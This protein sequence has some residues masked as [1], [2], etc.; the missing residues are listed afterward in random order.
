MAL[1]SSRTPSIDH[2]CPTCQVPDQRVTACGHCRS[3]FYCSRKCQSLDWNT[4]KTFCMKE[5]KELAVARRTKCLELLEWHSSGIFRY[6][7]NHDYV[8]RSSFLTVYD[9]ETAPRYIPFN[10]LEVL[11]KLD[12][13]LSERQYQALSHAIERTRRVGSDEAHCTGVPVLFMN[14][15]S[16]SVYVLGSQETTKLIEA[17]KTMPRALKSVIMTDVV[18][19]AMATWKP[20]QYVQLASMM[21]SGEADPI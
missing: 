14:G 21:A 9:E 6:I 17:V 11:N 16:R 10:K 15:E 20:S 18:K 19:S 8:G 7:F 5:D 13:K 3:I 1:S 2:M 4:H 12:L